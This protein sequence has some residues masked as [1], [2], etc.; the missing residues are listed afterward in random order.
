MQP[1]TDPVPAEEGDSLDPDDERVDVDDA[2]EID[3]EA[4]RRWDED[5][6]AE[7]EAPSG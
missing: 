3:D 6:V 1:D 4:Q 7:G 5:D 2:I